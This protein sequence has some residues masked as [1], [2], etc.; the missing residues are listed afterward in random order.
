MSL[1]FNTPVPQFV[2]FALNAADICSS[3]LT[4]PDLFFRHANGNASDTLSGA[5]PASIQTLCRRVTRACNARS[6][7]WRNR[8]ARRGADTLAARSACIAFSAL[9]YHLLQF[10]DTLLQQVILPLGGFQL[11]SVKGGFLISHRRRHHARAHLVAASG[12]ARRC[13]DRVGRLRHSLAVKVVGRVDG[14][15]WVA[16]NV[17]LTRSRR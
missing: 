1:C 15:R 8:C 4:N 12:A 11:A 6:S 16:T 9:A 13:S 2:S 10:S 17:G 5:R 3:A 7:R 14:C